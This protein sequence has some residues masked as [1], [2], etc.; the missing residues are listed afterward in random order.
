[1]NEMGLKFNKIVDFFLSMEKFGIPEMLFISLDVY[2][3]NTLNI[4]RTLVKCA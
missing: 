3:Q 2:L 4:I 1:M